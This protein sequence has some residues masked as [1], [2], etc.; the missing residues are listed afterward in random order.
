MTTLL[1]RLF[2]N[3]LESFDLMFKDFF[4]PDSFFLPAITSNTKYPVDIHETDN[5]LNIEIAIAGIDKEDINIE[6]C[7]GVLKVSYDKQDKQEIEQRNYIQKGIARRS[8]NLGWKI[9]EKFD[10]KKIEASIDKGLLK[11]EIPRSEE[12]QV[13]KKSIQIKDVKQ[14]KNK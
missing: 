1:P 10:L 12:K 11:I 14:L 13:I 4:S 8:F 2:N 3:D 7:D 6:E 5:A 9:S